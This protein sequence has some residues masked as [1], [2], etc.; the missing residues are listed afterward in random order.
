MP[1]PQKMYLST[2]RFIV[3]V[4]ETAILII[5]FTGPC[6]NEQR[7]AVYMNSIGFGVPAVGTTSRT[8]FWVLMLC[9]SRKTRRFGGAYGLHLYISPPSAALLLVFF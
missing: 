9:S 3:H 4:H 5:S 2:S 6:F 8:L 7:S 1:G